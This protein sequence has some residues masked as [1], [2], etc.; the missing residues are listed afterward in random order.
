MRL[1][2]ATL[3]SLLRP[4]TKLVVLNAP[5][6]PTGAV[7]SHDEFARIV[8]ACRASG[9]H[10]LVDEMYRG[11]EHE[12]M[13]ATLPAACD[14]YPERGVSL[15]G[16]SK[17]V[18]LPGLRLGWLASRDEALMARVAQLKDYTTICP[19][20]PSEVLG[21]IA[22]RARSA[23]L[24]RS[25]ATVAEGLEAAR[26][27]VGRHEE[28][29]AWAEPRGGTFAFVKLRGRAG[30]EAYCDALR[31][32]ANLMLMPGAL[33]DLDAEPEERGDAAQ[34][35]RLTFGRAGTAPLLE[36]WSADLQQHGG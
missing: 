31:A 29:L 14:A 21:F 13:G 27:M 8:R 36:R 24:A 17:T 6:N 11:L 20:S 28:Q 19:P 3:E 1:G 7:P 25:R 15:C 10:L 22:L 35:V 12:G 34:R 32:R 26:A 4:T 5:H 30:S 33:F 23:L 2:G 9:C 18:G 16:L